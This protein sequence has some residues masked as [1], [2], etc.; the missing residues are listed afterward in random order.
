MFFH[1]ASLTDTLSS[2]HKQASASVSC[3]CLFNSRRAAKSLW[4]CTRSL[5]YADVYY[6]SNAPANA[7]ACRQRSDTCISTPVRSARAVILV[8]VYTR[9]DQ[10]TIKVTRPARFGL[11]FNDVSGWHTSIFRKR[12]RRLYDRLEKTQELNA[13]EPFI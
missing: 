1:I 8:S 7:A 5:Y 4:T 11:V 13:A 3:V 12:T 9:L 10:L 6:D 2:T